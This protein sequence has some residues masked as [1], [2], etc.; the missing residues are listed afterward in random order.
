[1]LSAASPPKRCKI[2]AI[3]VKSSKTRYILLY[4]IMDLART[5][6][7]NHKTNNSVQEQGFVLVATLFAVALIALGASYFANRVDALRNSAFETQRWAEAER[8]AFS[9]RETLLHAAAIYPRDVAGL[10]T[11]DGALATDA[12]LY[13]VSP[14]TSMRIQDERGLIS[15]NLAEDP[16]LVRLFTNF[17]IPAEQHAKLLDSLRDYID[18]DDLKHLN[19]AEK[20]DYIAAGKPPPANDF[21]YSREQLADVLGWE[22]IFDP[23]NRAESDAQFDLNQTASESTTEST[24]AIGIRERFLAQF[25]TSRH[26][27]ININAA[28]VSVLSILPGIDPNRIGALI[29][30]RRARPF[31]NLNEL[32]PF[33]NSPLNEDTI[34][35]VGANAWRVTIA[36]AGL[37]FL[38]EC[39]LTI[40]PGERDRPTRLKACRR[41]SPDIFANGSVNEFAMALRERST[42]PPL[43][44]IRPTRQNN[45]LNF[46]DRNKLRTPTNDRPDETPAPR[47]LAEAIA[48]NASESRTVR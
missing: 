36:K 2:S 26:F 44:N 38:L 41:R 35:L 8:E 5:T 24:K 1:V 3:N 14:T 45:E 18:P 46:A 16:L 37:P 47:W 7:H 39:Q 15:I 28:P 27:G 33:A 25:S 9:L 31:R 29:D 11:N 17:G 19:G 42:A 32:L 6:P 40:T 12:R 23:L 4:F 21:I 30:Q 10:I 22:R 43:A 13:Q 20:S 34:G 48:S